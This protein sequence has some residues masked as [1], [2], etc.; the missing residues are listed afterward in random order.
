MITALYIL[1]ITA[2]SLLLGAG[3]LHL[4]PRLGKPGR[5]LSAFFCRGI[6]LDLLITYF[7]VLPMIVGLILY[8]WIGLLA[9]IA[10]QVVGLLIWIQLHELAHPAARK[11]PRIV[12]VLNKSA[13]RFNNHLALWITALAVPVFWLVR[14]AEWIVYPPLTWTVR[15]PAYKHS[16]WVNVSRHKF[17]GLVGHDL[18]WCLYCD[19]MTGIWSLGT[20]MLRNVESFWCPI[21]FY[22]GN[23]CENCKTDF[24]D[25]DGGWVD[26]DGNMKQVADVLTEKHAQGDHSWFGHPGRVTVEG[27][28][29]K[30][31]PASDDQDNEKPNGE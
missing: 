25:I 12:K 5:T 8:M 10:G 19:W 14:L 3:V 23:K 21:R 17:E 9:A 20:E 31:I 7:T 1:L 11:G 24:P 22:D 18:I 29:Q 15:L 2:A 4:L 16:E 13:G 28:P 27:Q 6:G 26:A 30:D